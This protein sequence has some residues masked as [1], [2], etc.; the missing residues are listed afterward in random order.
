MNTGEEL[1]LEEIEMSV[2]KSLDLLVTYTFQ[3]D[4]RHHV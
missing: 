2:D 3:L 4:Q 1:Y